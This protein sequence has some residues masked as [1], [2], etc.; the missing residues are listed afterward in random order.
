MHSGDAK[1]ADLVGENL[2]KKK[3]KNGRRRVGEGSRKG[4]REEDGADLLPRNPHLI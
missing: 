2:Q 4:N 3:K 1:I